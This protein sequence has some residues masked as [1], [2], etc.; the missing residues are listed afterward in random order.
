MSSTHWSDSL[1]FSAWNYM[2]IG[3][4]KHVLL[5]I[6]YKQKS[7]PQLNHPSGPIVCMPIVSTSFS[8]TYGNVASPARMKWTFK[9]EHSF[10]KCNFF[11]IHLHC[12]ELFCPKNQHRHKFAL[13]L[14][15][16]LVTTLVVVVVGRIKLLNSN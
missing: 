7:L 5:Y 3:A 11:S 1:H 8:P 6:L 14:L 10:F 12:S 15:F 4:V 9:F 2:E 16:A 13:R